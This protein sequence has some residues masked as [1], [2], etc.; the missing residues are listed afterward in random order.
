VPGSAETALTVS[1]SYTVPTITVTIHDAFLGLLE[2][3][4]NDGERELVRAVS[5]GAVLL[6]N[7]ESARGISEEIVSTII[8]SDDARFLHLFSSPSSVRDELSQFERPTARTVQEPDRALATVG[9]AWH[10][11]EPSENEI[12]IAG[13]DECNQFLNRVVDTLWDRIRTSLKGIERKALVTQCLRNHEG[14]QLDRDLWRRTSRAL[15]AVYKDRDDIVAAAHKHEAGFSRATLASRV[16]VEMG[17]CTCPLGD[18]RRPGLAEFDELLAA[19]AHL[20]AL[21]YDSDAMRAGLIDPSIRVFPNGEFFTSGEFYETVLL[22]YHSGRFAERFEENVNKY[23]DLYKLPERVGRPVDEVF[24]D[25]FISAFEVEYGLPLQQ[26]VRITEL[27]EEHAVRGEKMVVEITL[28]GI[29]DLLLSRL[30]LAAKEVDAFVTNFCFSPRE[31]WDSAPVGF[32]NKDWYPWRFRRR[33]SLM[34]RPIVQT[35]LGED[36]DLFYTPGLVQDAFANLVVGSS[37]GSFD[38]DYFASPEMKAWAG[39]VTNKRGHEFNERVAEEFRQL[40]CKARASVKMTEFNVPR[41]MGDLGDVDVVAWNA[42]GLVYIVECKNL[43]FAMTAGEISDQ[44]NRFRGEAQD[45]L[46]KH[47]RRCQWLNQNRDRLA[48]VIGASADPKIKPLLVSNT[49]VP[50]QFAQGLPIPAEDILPIGA[51]AERI[52]G[53]DLKETS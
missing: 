28:G 16:L 13:Q 17:V 38:T 46:S 37:G 36:G 25:R 2:R 48:R 26:L 41:E 44:L 14:V 49:I 19:A 15:T 39:A 6:S 32:V 52:V 20:I 3:P 31:R 12:E 7:M 42:T 30:R 27:L 18:G 23:P 35:G 4:A 21:A 51:L 24:D 22:P 33:L 1:V 9:L 50:M 40:N 5:E 43:R 53:R 45:E 10:V 47:M 8:T 11:L 34:A 29:K